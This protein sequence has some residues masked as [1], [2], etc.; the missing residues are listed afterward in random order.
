VPGTVVTLPSGRKYQLAGATG[1]ADPRPAVVGLTFSAHSGTW[2]NDAAWVTGHP[3]TTGWH[4]HAL[5]HDYTL[6]L[7]EPVSGAWNVGVG[8]G[9]P[10]PNGWPGSGQDDIGFVL[11]ATAD[12]GTRTPIDPAQTFVAGGSAGGALAARLSME[13][14][15]VYAACA[16]ASGWVPYRYPTAPW[17]CRLDHG[18]ADTTVPIRGGSGADGYIFPALYESTVRAPRGS[19]VGV[20]VIP[21]GGHGIPGWWANAIWAFFTTERARP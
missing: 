7:P 9:D 2:L 13:H 11:A 4:Q 20:Y 19:R 1:G 5:A 15:D 18:G 21:T 16:M 14:P 17:D 6:I 8:T 12:A 10:N 3:E